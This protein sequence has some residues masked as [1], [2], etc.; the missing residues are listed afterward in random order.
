[1]GLASRDMTIVGESGVRVLLD[2]RDAVG[3]EGESTKSY[4][5]LS[6]QLPERCCRASQFAPSPAIPDSIVHGR[7]QHARTHETVA[8]R[9]RVL[10]SKPGRLPGCRSPSKISAVSLSIERH[11]DGS[12]RSRCVQASTPVL[13]VPTVCDQPFTGH[14]YL[15]RAEKPIKLDLRQEPLHETQDSN[16]IVEEQ[17]EA[18]VDGSSSSGTA[19]IQVMVSYSPSYQ[20]PVLYFRAYDAG[21]PSRTTSTRS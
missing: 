9:F 11:W 1:M 2:E 16:G 20:V 21:R 19:S 14:G 18:N 7:K 8:C 5:S 4:K 3:E 6:A 12:G 13:I 17:D 15:V 10:N